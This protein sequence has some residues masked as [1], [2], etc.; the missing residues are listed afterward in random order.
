V[1]ELDEGEF[2][3]FLFRSKWQSRW[4]RRGIGV[5]IRD[6]MMPKVKRE[7]EKVWR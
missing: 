2:P 1:F 5:Q 4:G 6:E 7:C 3:K